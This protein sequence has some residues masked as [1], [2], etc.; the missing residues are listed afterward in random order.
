MMTQSL[1]HHHGNTEMA[2]KHLP[3]LNVTEKVAKEF[4]LLSDPSRL[5]IMTFL[6]HCEECVTDIA[7][8]CEMTA[9]A[10]SHHLKLLKD[11]GLLKTRREGK[12]MLYSLADSQ[13]A[14]I[15]HTIIDTVFEIKHNE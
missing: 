4:D 15:I 12:E 14:Q 9:P 8:V 10:V 2:I 5:R 11:G 1:P 3:E 7:T 13:E 6:C